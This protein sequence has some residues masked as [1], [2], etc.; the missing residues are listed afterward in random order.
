MPAPGASAARCASAGAASPV[1]P[2]LLQPLPPVALGKGSCA[3]FSCG[4]HSTPVH[5]CAA[6]QPA[7]HAQLSLPRGTQA[8]GRTFFSDGKLTGRGTASLAP[9][10][11]LC[12]SDATGSVWHLLGTA[13]VDSRPGG[14]SGGSSGAV[15]GRQPGARRDLPAT[16]GC[17]ASWQRLQ[18][19]RKPSGGPRA[20]PCT[21]LRAAG[22]SAAAG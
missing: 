8:P 2:P 1:G 20:H 3:A 22:A 5:L 21:A 12:S 14:G 15:A 16:A 4:T 13:A 17:R 18:G 7:R 19:G 11:V 10:L 6:A 9:A